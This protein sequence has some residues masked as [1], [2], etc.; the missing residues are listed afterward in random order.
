MLVGTLPGALWRAASG[1]PRRQQGHP[2]GTC[3]RR[4]A[5]PRRAW[6]PLDRSGVYGAIELPSQVLLAGWRHGLLDDDALIPPA[7][8]LARPANQLRRSN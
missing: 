6:S 1:Q 3:A 4:A 5:R 8:I 7:P 2:E